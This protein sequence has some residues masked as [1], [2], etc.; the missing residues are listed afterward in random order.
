MIKDNLVKVK[1]EAKNAKRQASLLKSK[2]EFARK[3]TEQRMATTL[4]SSSVDQEELVSLY[5]ALVDEELFDLDNDDAIAPYE[6]FLKEVEDNLKMGEN[7]DS[8]H[9][10]FK[11]VKHKILE[12]VKGKKVE[13]RQRRD[14]IGSISSICSQGLKN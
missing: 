8:G 3:V 2:V 7:S 5:S 9:E 14:S 6:G 13:R 4:P 1:M 12:K 10:H 11:I